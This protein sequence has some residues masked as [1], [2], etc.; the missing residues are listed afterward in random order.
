MFVPD[1]S[2]STDKEDTVVTNFAKLLIKAVEEK[3][4]VALC[5]SGQGE[6]RVVEP[7]A[8][9]F[10]NSGKL[11]MDG[12][13]TR[14]Y[15]SSGKTSPYWRVFRLKKITAISI[16]KEVFVPREDDGFSTFKYLGERKIF[17]IVD[18][19]PCYE[20]MSP[21]HRHQAAQTIE[22]TPSTIQ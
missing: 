5:Y 15:S 18:D 14:G 12:Y 22:A 4:C 1:L 2:V 20:P 19:K 10:D 7:H 17:A 3:R 16:L 11:I 8:V 6:I 21:F 9:Y 13:Q